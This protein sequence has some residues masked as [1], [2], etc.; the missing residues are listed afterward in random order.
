MLS[1]IVV[2]WNVK[3]LLE[4]CLESIF[5]YIK[6]IDF[7]VIV[8]DNASKDGSVSM[9]KEKFDQV[10]LIDNKKN[11]G[12][13]KANN[14]GME[15]AQ[16]KYILVLNDD[17]RLV[18]NSLEKLVELMEENKDWAIAGCKLLNKDKSL[19]ESVRRFPKFLDQLLILLKLHHL[20]L[21]KKYLNN[22]LVKDFD[23]MKFSE[24]DQIMGALMMMRKSVIDKIG[25]FD[26][27]YF[28]WFEEVDLCKRA[29]DKGLK[30]VYTPE[31]NVIHYGGASFAQVDW[32][33]QIIW[34]HSVCRYFWKHESKLTWFALW[35]LGP[36][37]V[38]LAVSA[39]LFKKRK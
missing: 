16:G 28:Y 36:V 15:M 25:K 3:D 18:D 7:E 6:N 19:Q 33:K 5:K 22:Y 8:V 31:V 13:A 2:S 21:F 10:K 26:E 39:G 12:F 37:S 38:L 20:P 11:L 17:T 35:I 4:K 32:H 1:I 34:N 24:V 23:Y 27:K 9:V 29:E 14:Q 30:V